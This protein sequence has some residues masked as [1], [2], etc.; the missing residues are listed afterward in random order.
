MSNSFIDKNTWTIFKMKR[1]RTCRNKTKER[2][3]H[4]IDK[5]RRKKIIETYN[6]RKDEIFDWLTNEIRSMRHIH[7][8]HFDRFQSNLREI[9]H[10]DEHLK[11]QK[12]RF[13]SI[14]TT[15]Q[16][17]VFYS[18]KSMSNFENS[19]ELLQGDWHRHNKKNSLTN[20]QVTTNEIREDCEI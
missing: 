17:N 12:H 7:T 13:S 15:K 19:I 14:S 8:F 16:I 10:L 6:E 2:I 1:K 20:L 9:L 11:W 3:C 4:S 5:N 18:N